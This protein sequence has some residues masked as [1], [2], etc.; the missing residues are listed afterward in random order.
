MSIRTYQE[1]M[2]VFGSA[3]RQLHPNEADAAFSEKDLSNVRFKL[4]DLADRLLDLCSK[5]RDDLYVDSR[6]LR[7]SRAVGLILTDDG[8][9]KLGEVHLA[10]FEDHVNVTT[11]ILIKTA[12]VDGHTVDTFGIQSCSIK[13]LEFERMLKETSLL[14]GSG[15][16]EKAK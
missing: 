7:Q 13:R 9:N 14:G 8:R 16:E 4:R 12:I 3:L 5:A 2:D 10:A 6:L 15:L 1:D 11:R